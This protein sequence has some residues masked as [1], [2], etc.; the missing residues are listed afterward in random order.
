MSDTAWYVT[1]TECPICGGQAEAGSREVS[2]TMWVPSWW[3]EE[4][5]ETATRT[6]H[7]FQCLNPECGYVDVEP[8][9]Y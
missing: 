6:E 2:W 7:Y 1:T 4:E 3:G 8:A 5:Y 9:T